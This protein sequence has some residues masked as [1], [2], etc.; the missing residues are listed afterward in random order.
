MYPRLRTD[1]HYVITYVSYRL[2]IPYDTPV[3]PLMTIYGTM[4]VPNYAKIGGKIRGRTRIREIRV[5]K[6]K[7]VIFRPQ[8]MINCSFLSPGFPVIDAHS[9]KL[10]VSSMVIR[11][12]A[13]SPPGNRPTLNGKLHQLSHTYLFLSSI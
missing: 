1:G 11:S 13:K 2:I 5:F 9:A 10:R 8:T 6:K 4:Y 3:P 12:V 7:G